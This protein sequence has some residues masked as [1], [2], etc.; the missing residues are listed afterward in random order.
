MQKKKE[1]S[2]QEIKKQL[3]SIIKSMLNPHMV[4]KYLRPISKGRCWTFFSLVD[5]IS[6]I[7]CWM[8][9]EVLLALPTGIYPCTLTQYPRI[10]I[11]FYFQIPR[12]SLQSTLVLTRGVGF[13]SPFQSKSCS[14]V[15][16]QLVWLPVVWAKGL[17]MFAESHSGPNFCSCSDIWATSRGSSGCISVC[18]LLHFCIDHFTFLSS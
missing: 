18:L 9:L 1:K 8:M 17:Q 5:S 4:W 15:S 3:Y 6:I 16:L 10:D 11:H 2:N 12:P 14:L 13:W 7:N